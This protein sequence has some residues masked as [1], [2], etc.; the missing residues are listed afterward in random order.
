[1]RWGRD[2]DKA[3]ALEVDDVVEVIAGTASELRA[4]A[5]RRAASHER[6][7]EIAERLE[8]LAERLRVEPDA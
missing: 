4:E 5:D 3:V 2:K 6:M 1:M 7:N 8:Q